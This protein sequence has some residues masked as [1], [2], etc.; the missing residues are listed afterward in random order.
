MLISR[1]WHELRRSVIKQ[2]VIVKVVIAFESTDAIPI[3]VV[4]VV[5]VVVIVVV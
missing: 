4:V 3:V 2:V 1:R 5:V